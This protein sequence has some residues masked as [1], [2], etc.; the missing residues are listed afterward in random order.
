MKLLKVKATNFKNCIDGIEIDLIARSKKT[1]EDKEYEL[2]EIAEDLF[3]YNTMAFIGKNASGK[4]TAVELL[5]CCY[6]ILENFSFT[7]KNVV[8]NNTELEMFFY[9]DGFI[10]RY[11][12]K[13]TTDIA[14]SG[15]VNFENEI[16]TYKKYYK[17]YANNVY[18]DTGF[19]PYKNVNELPD[20]TSMVFFP[21]KKKQLRYIYYGCDGLSVMTYPLLFKYIDNFKISDKV[22][23]KVINIFDE[24]IDSLTKTETDTYRLV[25]NGKEKLL[26]AN[27]LYHVLS[28]GTT[29]GM[30]LYLAVVISLK[31]GADLII[32]EIEN[33]FHKTLVE[34]ILNL[35]KDKNVNKYNSTLIFTTHYCEILDSFNRQDNI[36]IAKC[37]N[38]V[39]LENMYSDYNERNELLKSKMF[40]NNVFKTAV[41]YEALMSLKKELLL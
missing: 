24:N 15:K 3:V 4:T 11:R 23:Q 35:Y 10:Y 8:F 12:T 9:H 29:K 28:S 40:Y 34:N 41:N 13:M 5:N 33:H 30:M 37:S 7:D 16:L 39:T 38:K 18:S 2:Q 17:S 6:S 21:I 26:S 36:W 32:D 20:D 22:V 14:L 27:N 19:I 31:Y 1:A 25:Y